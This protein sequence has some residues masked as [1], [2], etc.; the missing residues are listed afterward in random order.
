MIYLKE[1]FFNIE[2][3]LS[4]IM[5][6]QKSNL[7][8]RNE[9]LEKEKEKIDV[10]RMLS[11]KK[12]TVNIIDAEIKSTKA[13][14]ITYVATTKRNYMDSISKNTSEIK[15]LNQNLI[16]LKNKFRLQVITAPVSGYVQQLSVHKIGGVV[17]SAQELLVIVPYNQT[18]EAEV[19][20]LNKDVGFVHRGQEV[21]VKI[22][23]FP[24]TR[25]GLLIGEV[26]FIS[27][28]SVTHSELGLVF[29]ARIKLNTYH[30]LVEENKTPLQAGMSVTVEILTG[31]RKIIDYILSP[32]Q[33]YQSE[34]LRE[35]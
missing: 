8:S 29:P 35:R 10:N 5:V 16:K 9:V 7:I 33:K 2:Q 18:L 4:S 25:Y 11:Q 23:A 17:K 30:I 19:M 27:S 1:L 6:L 20:I 32:L 31:R 13:G 22:D 28:D 21:Q 14:R 24:Y 26:M 15:L 3:R 34:A 12:S